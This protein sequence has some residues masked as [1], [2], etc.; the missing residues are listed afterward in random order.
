[1]GVW[2]LENHGLEW[3]N[4]HYCI[5]LLKVRHFGRNLSCKVLLVLLGVLVVILVVLVCIEVVEVHVIRSFCLED[6]AFQG[7]YLF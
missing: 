5:T 2:S 4:G 7:F 6:V 1:M 3:D